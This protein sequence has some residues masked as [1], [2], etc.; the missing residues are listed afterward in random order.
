MESGLP[1]AQ[2]LY[3]PNHEHDSCGVG[4]IV[5]LKG[6]KSHQVVRD[7]ITALVNL[8]HRGA[9]GCENNTGD[10]AGLLDPDP[11][12]VSR[13][14]GARSSGSRCRSP[15]A[16]AWGRSSPRRSGGDQQRFGMELFERIV[17]EEGQIFLGWRR[18]R[19]TTRRWASPPGRS[20]RACS[21]PSSA[22]ARSSTTTTRS[23]ASST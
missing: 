5:D 19:P 15:A 1:R 23:S 12:R 17:A 3:D 8:N 6:R 14:R 2:G 18:S 9:C 13:S 7:G 20:S 16:T 21:T 10:G 11:P 4:F 22:A